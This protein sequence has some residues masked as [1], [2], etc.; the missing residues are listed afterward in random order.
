MRCKIIMSFLLF[1]LLYS[2]SSAQTLKPT[3]QSLSLNS[4]DAFQ[5]PAANW[6]LVGAVQSAYTDTVLTTAKGV[7]IVYNDYSKSIQFVP[8]H[9]LV[10]TMEHGDMYFECDVMLPR[11]TNSGIYFQSR[12]EVQ[13][14]DSWGVKV[15]RY[16]DMGGIYERAA[17]NGKGFEGNSPLQNAGKAP[18]LWQHLEITFQAPR[19]DAAGKKITPAKFVSIKLNG[20]TIHENIFVSGPTRSAA[21]ENEKPYGP[22]MIQGDHGP[23]A[24]KNIKYALQDNFNAKLSDISYK[25]YEKTAKSLAETAQIKPTSQ[26]KISSL[27]ASVAPVRDNFFLT[28]EG[29]MDLPTKD[30]YTFSMMYTGEASLLIDGKTVINPTITTISGTPNKGSAQLEGGSHTFQI[31]MKKYIDWERP[32]LGL[33]VEKA[34]SKAIAL[35]KSSG[36]PDRSPAPL[37]SVEPQKE[38]EMVRSFMYQGD[39]KLTHIVSVGHPAKLHYAYDLLQGGILKIWKGQF[40]NTTDM[41]YQRGEPQTATP[42]GASFDL[43]GTSLVFESKNVKDSIAAIQYKGYTLSGAGNPTF[44]YVYKNFNLVDQ[45]LPNENASGFIRKIQVEGV[46]KEKLMIR[47]AQGKT[48]TPV[49]QGLYAIDNSSYYIQVAPGVFPKLDNFNKDMVLLMPASE[50]IQYQLIW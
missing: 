46:G 45:L 16:S 13:L 8:G 41:W 3:L 5:S 11:K 38:T 19:F 23:L 1:V 15:P 33:F 50:T 30:N 6:K 29:K 49:G 47:I 36:L 43:A 25:Y 31:W 10:T 24:I 21:F 27:D 28:F 18:G 42:L 26:G 37:I 22:L 34:N 2:I 40:L 48:I 14:N 7:G 9:H 32:G 20:V 44:S 39:K 12:Y 4:L 17:A 35:H